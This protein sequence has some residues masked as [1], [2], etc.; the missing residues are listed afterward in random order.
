MASGDENTP[1]AMW[2]AVLLITLQSFLFG[3]CFSSLNPCLVTGD[4]TSGSACFHG[5]DSGC[6]KGTI[7][8]D[9][10]LSTSEYFVI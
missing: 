7:Y 8:N 10:N 9:L 1:S 2:S 6:P 5:T 3:Y 4:S